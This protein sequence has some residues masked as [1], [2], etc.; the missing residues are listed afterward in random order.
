MYVYEY[1]IV[2]Q[3]T[4]CPLNCFHNII[5]KR[6]CHS[7]Q[8]DRFV[9]VLQILFHWP[10]FVFLFWCPVVAPFW[11]TKVPPWSLVWALHCGNSSASARSNR[12]P[13]RRR[14]MKP[15]QEA[16]KGKRSAWDSRGGN[17]TGSQ[18][19]VMW[20]RRRYF[21]KQIMSEC[22]PGGIV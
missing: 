7:C 15:S 9:T 10:T 17:L 21:A 20:L 8:L 13:Q 16:H 14:G 12:V 22:V 5:K 19:P 4:S 18:F 11:K 2:S 3:A 6:F 1:R